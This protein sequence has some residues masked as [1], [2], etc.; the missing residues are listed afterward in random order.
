MTL[1]HHYS[2]LHVI[3]NALLN[4]IY[5]FMISMRQTCQIAE[6]HQRSE[7]YIHVVD[8]KK[9]PL[10]LLPSAN[11]MKIEHFPIACYNKHHNLELFRSVLLFH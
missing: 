9:L 7:V 3:V 10:P 6:M 2:M 11:Q 5:N 1:H 8:F 4:F